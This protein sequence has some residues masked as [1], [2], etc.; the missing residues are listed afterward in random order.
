MG[1]I[2]QLGWAALERPLADQL[3]GE[4]AAQKLAGQSA[5]FREGV[6]AFAEKRKPRF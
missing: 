1:L 2:R 3:A 6:M 4:R 5:E